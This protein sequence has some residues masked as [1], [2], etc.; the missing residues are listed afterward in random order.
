MLKKFSTG[1]KRQFKIWPW[2]RVGL[3]LILW[4]M[5]TML[6]IQLFYP[7]NKLLPYQK[8]DDLAVGGDTHD[9]AIRKLDSAYMDKVVEVFLQ[10]NAKPVNSPKLSSAGVKVNTDGVVK[11]YDYPWYLRLVPSSIFWAGNG[12]D[13][14]PKVE[15]T[16]KTDE[17][18]T[19]IL[20]K[21]CQVAPQNATLKAEGAKLSVVNAK[22]G[23]ECNPDTVKKEFMTLKP[24]LNEP[25]KVTI[26]VKELT[27]E[28][29]NEEAQAA[30]ESIMSLVG[31]GVPLRV[32]GQ[33]VVVT[34]NDFYAWLEF[35]PS[36]DTV[37]AKVSAEK[38]QD[39]LAKNITPKVVVAPGKATITTRDFA[40]ISRTGGGDGQTLNID[41][42][43][44]SLNDFLNQQSNTAEAIT[45][46]VPATINY[47][48]T[49]SST[50]EGINALLSNFAKDH[51]GTYGISYAE[52]SGDRRRANYQG[53]KK[54]VTASTYKLFVA[55]SVLKRV[56]SGQ[57]S[58]EDNQACFNKMISFSDNPCS[59]VFL[60]KVGLGTVTKEINALGLKNSNFTEQGGPFTTA[61]DL[62]TF[63]GTLQSDSMFSGT[64]RE[65]LISA[66][67]GNV[68]RKGIPA[69]AGETVADKVGFMDGLLHDAAIVYSPKGTYVLAIMTEGSSWEN[70]AELT[71]ELEKLR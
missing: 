18:I 54:F 66:M 22:V 8:I 23:G 59:E 62:V 43:V 67:T 16:S 26:S 36:A 69:G 49:Y 33:Q 20:M 5:G 9:E 68:Y 44:R 50:D 55:Y 27:A 58:W 19:T 51:S 32:S 52:L 61:N 41:A 63:L 46:V 60:Q 71:R 1:V 15:F 57:M 24:V 65:R 7:I 47:I 30:G 13:N 48:R 70:I 4:A 31:N 42:T 3:L 39:Y 29:T 17:F 35:T 12:K 11:Q 37:Q 56:E 40:E 28:V 21:E 25:A 38:A 2:K 45:Q 10:N 6:I 64:S 14:T 53:D 34:A